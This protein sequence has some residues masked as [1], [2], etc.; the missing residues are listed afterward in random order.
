MPEIVS[1][2]KE[3]VTLYQREHGGVLPPNMEAIYDYMQEAGEL[4]WSAPPV[5]N[6]STKNIE[7]IGVST[8]PGARP[9]DPASTGRRP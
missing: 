6:I 1:T 9:S 5:T 4:S 7:P 3:Y 2:L 8:P